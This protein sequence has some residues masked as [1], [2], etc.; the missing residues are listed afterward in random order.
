[1]IPVLTPAEMGA[2]DAAAPEAVEV[3]VRRAAGAVAHTALDL[4][5]QG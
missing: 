3:L 5:G 1:M 4:L 2:V